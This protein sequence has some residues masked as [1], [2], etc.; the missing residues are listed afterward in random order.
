MTTL[1][2]TKKETL[3]FL[4]WLEKY[5]QFTGAN[6]DEVYEKVLYANKRITDEIFE[7][8]DFPFSYS[9]A[10]R[11]TMKMFQEEYI[12]DAEKYGFE[13]SKDLFWWEI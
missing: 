2:A 6:E 11:R 9:S 4:Q 7:D 1:T 8:E 5:Y 10:E 13:R 12:E 3:T